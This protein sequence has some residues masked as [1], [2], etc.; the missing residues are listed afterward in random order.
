M[1]PLVPT[2]S[3][4]IGYGPHAVRNPST[5][6]EP[7]PLPHRPDQLSQPEQFWPDRKLSSRHT[8]PVVPVCLKAEGGTS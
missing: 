6:H 5:G 3:S 7:A 4:L 2:A 1:N 8:T